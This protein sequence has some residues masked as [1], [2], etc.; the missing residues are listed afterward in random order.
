MSEPVRKME[1][2]VKLKDH[3]MTP[4]E[5]IV[6]YGKGNSDVT[7]YRKIEKD[8]G[9]KI[10]SRRFKEGEEI[11]KG[12][13]DSPAKLGAPESAPQITPRGADEYDTVVV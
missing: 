13:V 1:E 6:R 10:V 3:Q 4:E 5:L 12:W 8:G 11:P 7:L 9:S 2:L